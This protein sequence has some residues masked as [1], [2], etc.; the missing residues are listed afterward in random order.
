M[1]T[2]R[3]ELANKDVY[4]VDRNIENVGSEM[5]IKQK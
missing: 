1:D 3:E 5:E 4:T 2:Q